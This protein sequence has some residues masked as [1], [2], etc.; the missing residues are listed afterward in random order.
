M[1]R[2]LL[3]KVLYV[4]EYGLHCACL[5]WIHVGHVNFM[6]FVFVL[7]RRERGFW[8]NMGLTRAIP[9]PR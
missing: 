4:L 5:H 7:F 8:W 9:I 3:E 1:G 2:T 6:L